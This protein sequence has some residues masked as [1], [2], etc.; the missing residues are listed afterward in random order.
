MSLGW[1]AMLAFW[2]AAIVGIVLLVR[3]LSRP[4]PGASTRSADDALTILRWRY[5]SGEI[6]HQ[7]YEQMRHTLDDGLATSR[8]A[9]TGDKPV[10][11]ALIFKNGVPPTS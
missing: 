3:A 1:L 11:K 8:S 7:Q 9:W 6:T 5:A 10:P 2:G 4:M